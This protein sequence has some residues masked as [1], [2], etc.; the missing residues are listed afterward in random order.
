MS[1]SVLLA[2]STSRD[3]G[4]AYRIGTG[5]GHHG[6]QGSFVRADTRVARMSATDSRHLGLIYKFVTNRKS[7]VQTDDCEPIDRVFAPS[8][9]EPAV[10]DYTPRQ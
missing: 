3:A 7:L 1:R 10:E 8:S 6:A 4:A 2:R 5:H 9:L